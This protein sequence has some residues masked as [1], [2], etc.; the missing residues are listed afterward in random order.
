[1]RQQISISYITLCSILTIN[2]QTWNGSTS[3]DGNIWRNGNVGIGTSSPVYKISLGGQTGQVTTPLAFAFSN[4]YS[5]NSLVANS[6]LF[7]YNT[8]GTEVY[9]IGVLGNADIQYHAGSAGNT[10]GRHDFHSGNSL[11]M[12][13]QNN[14][15][16]GIGTT[17]PAAKL[18]IVGDIYIDN[19]DWSRDNVLRIREGSSNSYGAFFKYGLNDLLTIGTRNS[20]SELIAFQV[21]RGSSNVTFI[22]N[23][24]IGSTTPDQ[25]LTV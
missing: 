11:K 2:A 7:L 14:G 22:G 13:I 9:G 3:V 19:L 8:G 16:V 10:F 15:N 23:V 17:T 20:G 1:M 12:T 25:K 5:N 24:G 4:D 18:D 6:K 21:P